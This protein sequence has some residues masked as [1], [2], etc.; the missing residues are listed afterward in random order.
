MLEEIKDKIQKCE[1]ENKNDSIEEMVKH[2]KTSSQQIEDAQKSMDQ[3]VKTCIDRMDFVFG[4]LIKK[5]NVLISTQRFKD[6]LTLNQELED[7]E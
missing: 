3:Q 5:V 6:A 4:T 7:I 1:E 2:L